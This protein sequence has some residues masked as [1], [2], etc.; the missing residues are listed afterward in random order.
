M[1][2]EKLVESPVRIVSYWIIWRREV[3]FLQTTTVTN[4][5]KYKYIGKQLSHLGRI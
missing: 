5:T 4:A 2:E 3:K 1:W